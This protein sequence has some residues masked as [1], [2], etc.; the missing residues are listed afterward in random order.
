MQYFVSRI[1]FGKRRGLCVKVFKRRRGERAECN[2]LQRRVA[3]K[4]VCADCFHHVGEH[5][6]FDI[7]VLVAGKCVDFFRIVA[8]DKRFREL[9]RG[10]GRKLQ[11]ARRHLCIKHAVVQQRVI[12][13]FAVG[14]LFVA[15]VIRKSFERQTAVK[16]RR[17]YLIY[18]AR[19]DEFRKV[20]GKLERA[21][22][23]FFKIV[24]GERHRFCVLESV[25][26]DFFQVVC[27]DCAV[28]GALYGS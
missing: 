25:V 15:V 28:R 19:E 20:F 6:F 21:D 2:R 9:R 12:V 26:A 23:D 17:P 24:C 1:V 18:R 8:D 27:D 16:R 3:D 5:D 7:D 22:S 14:L 11:F 10:Y 13:D 4:R